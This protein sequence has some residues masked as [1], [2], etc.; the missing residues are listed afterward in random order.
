MSPRCR[1]T[2]IKLKWSLFNQ[3]QLGLLQISKDILY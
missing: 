2:E 1:Q 3:K